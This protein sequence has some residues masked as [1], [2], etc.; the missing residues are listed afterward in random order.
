MKLY[1]PLT[2]GT[3]LTFEGDHDE[4]V[5]VAE[6]FVEKHGDMVAVR[7]NINVEATPSRNVN[8]RGTRRWNE[9]TT[10]RLWKLL[11]GEQAKV[12][13]FLVERGGKAEYKELGKHM[14]YDAQH[15][16]GV[17]SAITRNAQTAT[18]DRLSRLVDW[19]ITDDHRREY[20]ID[21]EAM[22]FFSQLVV[23]TS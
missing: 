20:S 21:A 5:S 14:G 1:V 19:R 23:Q 12:V 17:L 16:S 4:L 7:S 11:Y 9:Q 3:T 18:G 13:R 8:Q 6:R 2:D 15:L 10:Q 22:P